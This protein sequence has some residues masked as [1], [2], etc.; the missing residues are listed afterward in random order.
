MQEISLTVNKLNKL[1]VH[2]ILR[3]YGVIS[4]KL[5]PAVLCMINF[6]IY[7]TNIFVCIKIIR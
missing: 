7:N 3:Y 4:I 5:I 2:N 1:I 6:T